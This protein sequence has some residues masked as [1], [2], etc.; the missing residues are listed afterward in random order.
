MSTESLTREEMMEPIERLFDRETGRDHGL[1]SIVRD[2]AAENDPEQGNVDLVY[3]AGDRNSL[4]SI[5]LETSFDTCLFDMDRGILS[6]NGVQANSSWI[7]L[8]LDEFREGDDEYNGIM[9]E[10]C[11]KRGIGIVAVQPKGRGISAKVLLEAQDH[12]GDYLAQY[13][14]LEQKWREDTRGVLVGD[15][16][17]VVEY[18]NR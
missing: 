4:H 3:I 7:A 11:K 8:P 6:L 9:E 1:F 2:E 17:R 12:A 15:D 18:Y 10:T 16:Y 13:P 14:E 5:R